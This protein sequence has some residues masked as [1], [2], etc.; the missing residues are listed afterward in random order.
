MGISK[1]NTDPIEFDYGSPPPPKLKGIFNSL[2]FRILVYG[3]I[4]IRGNTLVK[5]KQSVLISSLALI[6]ERC[7]MSKIMIV[8]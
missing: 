2:K 7:L 3:C 1:M 5:R 6:H 8:R 4:R